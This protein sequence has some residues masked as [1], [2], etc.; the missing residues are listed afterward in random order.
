[1]TL[2]ELQNKKQHPLKNPKK[3]GKKGYTDSGTLE[4]LHIEIIKEYSFLDYIVGGCDVSLMVAI[5]FTA[6]NGDPRY[7]NSLHYRNPYQPNEYEQAIMS[8]GE[9]L[10]CYDNDGMFPVYGFGASVS[11]LN[12]QTSHCFPL[13]TN[14]Q[15][16]EVPG[17]AG[18]LDV[19]RKSLD[20][21]RLYGPTNFSQVSDNAYLLTALLDNKR[22][23]FCSFQGN[24]S[25]K[26]K[27][28]Y[29]THYH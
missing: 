5:D 15:N 18:I 7:A 10:A 11:W 13:N 22:C 9:I 23:I 20:T 24:Y 4:V 14:F 8:V 19:Y 6:S 27:I 2:Q 17:I 1:V 16:P 26:P 29:L 3:E 12:N 28:P 25:T 21:V